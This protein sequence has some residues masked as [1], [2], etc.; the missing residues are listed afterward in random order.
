MPSVL[1][2][3]TANICRSPMA[4]A[5]FKQK[6]AQQPNAPDWRVESAGTWALGD[7]PAA[8]RSQAVMRE[9]GL[10]IASH[11]SRCVSLEL[12][13]PF[14]LILTMEQGHKEA[15]RVEFPE[16]SARIYL[17]SEMAGR[18][19]DIFDPMGGTI[20]DFR[21][22]ARELDR[23]LADGLDRIIQLAQSNANPMSGAPEA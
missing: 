12:L 7:E 20:E 10:N 3:C 4:M 14:N 19:Y 17:L 11:R 21:D 8:S 18:S 1:F 2:V 9:F 22:T 16:L 13:R 23:L 5:L 15:L 6:V